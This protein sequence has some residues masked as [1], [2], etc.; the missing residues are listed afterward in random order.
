VEPSKHGSDEPILLSGGNPQVAKGD[1][2]GPVQAYLDAMPGWKGDVGRSLDSIIVAEVP[3]VQ[4][5]VRWNSPFYGVEGDG[6]FLSFHCLTKYLKVTFFAG[7]SLNP[8]PPVN[9]KR[10]GVRYFHIFESEPLDEARFADWVRQASA[11]P[12]EALF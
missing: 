9:A 2:N 6:W 10:E 12:G 3:D 8:R 5:A 11:L 7:H 1:G 4:K